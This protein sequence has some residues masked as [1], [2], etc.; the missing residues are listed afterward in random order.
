[1]VSPPAAGR[2]FL[3]RARAC[4]AQGTGAWTAEE[5]VTTRMVPRGCGGAGPGYEWDQTPEAVEVRL[6]VPPGT[7]ARDVEVVAMPRRI[8]VAVR[9]AALLEGPLGGECV[10]PAIGDVEW[11][12]EGQGDARRL[13]ATLRKRGVVYE[14]SRQWDCLL[15]GDGHP[16]IDLARLR[17]DR[18]DRE[19]RPPQ[20]AQTLEEVAQ[21]LPG[22]TVSREPLAYQ[23][24][25]GEA[26]GEELAAWG[27]QWKG[28]RTATAAAASAKHD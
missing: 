9:G 26:D 11:E 13:L 5:L 24:R 18:T 14:P 27:G 7:A 8:R 6:A 25:P 10:G 1:M 2:S 16:K 23:R 19:W 17:W 15:E 21:A 12:L 22:N 3:L 4:N 20:N 28:K